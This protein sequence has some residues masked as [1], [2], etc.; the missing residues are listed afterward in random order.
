MSQLNVYVPNA[1]EKT[2]RKEAERAG[3]SLSKF[4][5]A[6]IE[7]HVK[8][9]PS[10]NRHFFTKVVGAWQGDFP[11]IKRALPEVRDTL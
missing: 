4:L 6:L 10:W 8:R 5:T 11:K 1:L 9:S 7:R 3:L 2:V